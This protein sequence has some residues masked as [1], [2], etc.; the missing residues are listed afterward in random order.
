[1][2]AV[3]RVVCQ[4]KFA[5]ISIMR[6]II[7]RTLEQHLSWHK[8]CILIPIPEPNSFAQFAIVVPSLACLATYAI[9][10]F[11]VSQEVTSDS[12]L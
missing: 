7:P 1:M 12:K 2:V 11:W 4:I 3:R 10:S 6:P 9:T 8:T 5:T